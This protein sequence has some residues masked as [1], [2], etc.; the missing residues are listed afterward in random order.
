M[1]K[2]LIRL[3]LEYEDGSISKL[4][5]EEAE[6]WDKAMSDVMWCYQNHGNKFPRFKWAK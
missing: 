1:K 3:E 2:K 4:I 5:G 6:K